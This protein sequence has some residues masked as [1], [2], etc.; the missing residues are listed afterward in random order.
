[1]LFVGF[2]HF[3]GKV[4]ITKTFSAT[5]VQLFGDLT[6]KKQEKLQNIC[7]FLAPKGNTSKEFYSKDLRIKGLNTTTR[8]S[9]L[10][11]TK[12]T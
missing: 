8:S 2:A 12:T 1:M 10:T 4:D 11:T 5:K 9:F 6:N 7:I 3:I